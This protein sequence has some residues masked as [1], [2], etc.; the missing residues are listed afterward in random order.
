MGE[1]FVVT[2]IPLVGI[3]EVV[4]D[5]VEIEFNLDVAVMG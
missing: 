3:E 2:V 5:V 4:N 1:W